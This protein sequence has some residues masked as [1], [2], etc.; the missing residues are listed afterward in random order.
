MLGVPTKSRDAADIS[1]G[2]QCTLSVFFAERGPNSGNLRL[3]SNVFTP[4]LPVSN[5]YMTSSIRKNLTSYSR[6][7]T[8]SG[9]CIFNQNNK[10]NNGLC[11][12]V[13][14]NGVTKKILRI[15]REEKA[16]P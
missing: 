13:L 6:M 11:I 16:G 7:Y 9:K 3:Y 14:P 2:T 1:I 5:K 15:V 4:E 10:A 12:L 8:L